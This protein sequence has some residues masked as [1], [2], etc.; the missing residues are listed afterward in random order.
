MNYCRPTV[1]GAFRSSIRLVSDADSPALSRTG[2]TVIR[3]RVVIPLQ[4]TT[5]GAWIEH[6]DGFLGRAAAGS[7]LSMPLGRTMAR[8]PPAR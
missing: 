8:P 6:S 7:T 1:S 3:H 4:V 5:W 2:S